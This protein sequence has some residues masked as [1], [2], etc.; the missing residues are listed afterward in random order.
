MKPSFRKKVKLSH[1]SIVEITDILYIIYDIFYICYTNF[2][3]II[4]DILCRYIYI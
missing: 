2:I 1:G 4:N 3:Y